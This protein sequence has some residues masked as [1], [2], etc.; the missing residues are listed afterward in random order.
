MLA[1]PFRQVGRIESVTGAAVAKEIGWLHNM[2]GVADCG[3]KACIAEIRW[4]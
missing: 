4:R 3:A 1:I 2:Q